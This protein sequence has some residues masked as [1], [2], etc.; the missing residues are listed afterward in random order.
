M[1]KRTEKMLTFDVEGQEVRC[2]LSSGDRL[3]RCECERFKLN[4]E[5]FKEGFCPHVIVAIERALTDGTFDPKSFLP[6]GNKR[7]R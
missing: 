6:G 1:P 3:W 2:F 7:R 5:R 4:L